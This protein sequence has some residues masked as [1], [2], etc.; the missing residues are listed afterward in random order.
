MR[1][2]WYFQT[3]VHPNRSV[4]L[5]EG[6]IIKISESLW[7]LEFLVVRTQWEE[8]LKKLGKTEVVA[9]IKLPEGDWILIYTFSKYIGGNMFVFALLNCR[10]D[11][12]CE[13]CCVSTFSPSEFWQHRASQIWKVDVRLPF[14]HCHAIAVTL[15][16]AVGQE[17][18]LRDQTLL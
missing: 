1:D 10:Y 16:T 17:G 15:V 5:R 7:Q 13:Y 12:M 18:T 2:C 11:A 9:G 6:N 8:T 4:E 3:L 14:G